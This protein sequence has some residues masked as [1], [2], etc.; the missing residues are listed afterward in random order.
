V[1]VNQIQQKIDEFYKPIRLSVAK[2]E[3]S[4]TLAKKMLQDKL[5]ELTVD[6]MVE[7]KNFLKPTEREFKEEEV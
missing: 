4:V 3:L 6:Q 1:S 7:D 5:F 2:G